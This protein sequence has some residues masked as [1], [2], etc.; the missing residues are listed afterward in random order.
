M[1][2]PWYRMEN[3]EIEILVKDASSGDK[4]AFKKLYKLKYDDIYFIAQKMVNNHH[5]AEDITQ[6]VVLIIHKKING[7]KDSQS[8]DAWVYSIVRNCSNAVLRKRVSRREDISKFE[9]GDDFD[10]LEDNKDIIPHENMEDADFAG[11]IAKIIGKLSPE[12]Q[13]CFHLY[14]D[15]DLRYK[16]ISKVMNISINTVASHIKR[17]KELIKMKLEK[18]TSYNI[19]FEKEGQEND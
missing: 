2:L 6:E 15:Q 3:N 11:Y 10:L 19:E 17:T 16:D 7:L 13:Q 12:R 14:F 8:F 18:D 9:H 1:C 4:D 5:D